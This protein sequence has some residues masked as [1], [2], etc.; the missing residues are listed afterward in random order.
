MDGALDTIYNFYTDGNISNATV[1]IKYDPEEIQ[2]Q[3]L[4]EDGLSLYYFDEETKELEEIP[5]TVDKENK[6]L[7][8]NL[9]HFSKYIIGDKKVILT[10]I[11]TDVLFVID[12]SVSM[13]NDEQ[14]IA[15]G[16]DDSQ[17]A[18]GND[19][20]FKR[21]SLTKNMISMFTGNYE[22]AASEF[23]G[24]YV[25]LNEFTSSTDVAQAA[26]ELM[27]NNWNSDANGTYIIN[28]LNSGISEFK[29][30]D[31]NHYLI[32]LTDDENTAGSLPLAKESIISTAKEKDV[33]ICIIGLGGSV[34]TDDLNEI[35]EF[36]GCDYYNATDSSALDEIYSIIG[37][38]INYGQVDVDGDGKA[39]GTTIADSGFVV[40]RDGFSFGN[41]GSNLAD[42]HC[43][44][45]A[46]F[47]ELYYIKKL[48]LT[49]SSKTTT[50]L[51]G[52][53]SYDAYAY[54][55]NYTYFDKY[56]NL[57]DY[58]LKSDVLKYKFY[59]EPIDFY[60]L[61]EGKLA[62][63]SK[64]KE[65]VSSLYDITTKESGLSEADQL[66]KHGAVYSTYED[67]SLI[68]EDKMQTSSFVDNDDKQ[69]FNAIYT[70]H[71]KQ[72]A[73]SEYSSA[74]NLRNFFGNLFGYY[75]VK[76]INSAD[77]VNLLMTR[78]KSGDAP[79]ISSRFYGDGGHA[80]NA[81]S[82]VQD[83]TN[84][85]LY[86]IGVYD[87][88]YPGEKRYVDM[89]CTKYSCVTVGNKD[90]PKSSNKPITMSVS[91]DEDLKFYE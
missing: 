38:D 44:G 75:S 3:G 82:L 40:T 60:E 68:N 42:G 32:L 20:L 83:N 19:T 13:Y 41:Y 9:E 51:R 10:K 53:V 1:K 46:T 84:A 76:K 56:D 26:V 31:N 16:Y 6:T 61:D 88:N 74:S 71:I 14:M 12:N 73:T 23:S 15:A 27:R 7:I 48:P 90:Y 81:I 50:A 34:D 79:V 80:I 43:Y 70:S 91:L 59:E 45:M 77:F 47:A 58:Q 85:N 36:T 64:Y 66:K 39:D 11:V 52:S 65:E 29:A 86:H 2:S 30:D 62:I 18:I 28:A 87:N 22:F 57:Y 24:N 35:A 37:A 63:S 72:H 25:K 55:L 49:V 33:K 89:E 8:A 78:L 5:T 54:D 4:N 17:G 67:I 21:L 69:L